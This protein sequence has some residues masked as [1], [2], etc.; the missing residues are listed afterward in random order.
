MTQRND[1][2]GKPALMKELNI[3]LIKDALVKNQ[4]ATRV[5]L[6]KFTNISQPTVNVLIKQL[7]EDGTVISL[8]TA[9]STGGRKAEIYTLN[10]KRNQLA[11][12]IVK[13]ELFEYAVMDFKL[14]EEYAGKT[15]RDQR[16]SYLEQ[17]YGI[18]QN[19]LKENPYINAIVVG[20][21]GAV[22]KNGEVFDIPKI[23]ELE[24]VN[25]EVILREKFQL[26][27]KIVNDIN[28]IA[29]GYSKKNDDSTQNM[30][31]LHLGTDGIGA[32]IVI[33]GNLYQG[34]RSF[35]GEIGHMQIDQRE[36]VRTR[37][38]GGDETQKKV[39]LGKIVSNLI[40]VLNPE[41]IVIGGN[42]CGDIT[43][44]LELE[45]EKYL[46][47]NVVPKLL[48]VEDGQPYYVY[49]LATIAKEL[50]DKEIRLEKTRE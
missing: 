38:T 26:P 4:Q 11:A 47:E 29:V 35:A 20:V 19:I 9:K 50:S 15:E 42:I 6:S 7:L 10:H 8:G 32:G 39:A 2:T 49:G 40:C 12:V 44:E 46:P 24:H 43:K 37:L 3:G 23:P 16:K 21:P 1:L 13:E 22:L 31:Y 41:K 25:L 30:V 33:E 17:L 48:F 14:C 28:A 45:C 36:S 5:Q 18:L 27:V 34:C